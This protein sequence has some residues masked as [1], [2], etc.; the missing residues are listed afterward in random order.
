MCVCERERLVWLGSIVVRKY[1]SESSG[2]RNECVEMKESL[3][4][5]DGELV[6]RDVGRREG[7]R[8]RRYGEGDRR[9]KER[10]PIGMRV[11]IGRRKVRM[12]VEERIDVSSMIRRRMVMRGKGVENQSDKM[13]GLMIISIGGI[14]GRMEIEMRSIGEIR[15]GE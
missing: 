10:G 5:E 8:S 1:S 2:R 6:E 12:V 3:E 9:E 11:S 7:E 4:E 14:E 15:R 13:I